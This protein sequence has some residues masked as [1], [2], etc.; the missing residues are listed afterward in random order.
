MIKFKGM[1]NKSYINVPI[2]LSKTILRTTYVLEKKN[3]LINNIK[4]NNSE[5]IIFIK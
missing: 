2:I 3:M 5:I 4:N 1:F